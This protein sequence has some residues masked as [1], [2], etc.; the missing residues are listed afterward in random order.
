MANKKVQAIIELRD[1]NKWT[2]Q[3]RADFEQWVDVIVQKVI[4]RRLPTG[5]SDNYEDRLF[6]NFEDRRT[7]A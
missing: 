5:V 3:E 7:D 6:R 2:P 1:V 4:E